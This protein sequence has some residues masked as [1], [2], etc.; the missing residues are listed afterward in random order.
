MVPNVS[1]CGSVGSGEKWV[2]RALGAAVSFEQE[3]VKLRCKQP[4]LPAIS[5][6]TLGE[7]GEGLQGG[8]PAAVPQRTIAVLLPSLC[9]YGQH[10]FHMAD[11]S[12]T[13][14]HVIWGEQN[15]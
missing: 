2:F 11:P 8:R 12:V 3:S 15:L 1:Y 14:D 13:Q 6:A 9:I 5:H 7:S 4:W 10:S